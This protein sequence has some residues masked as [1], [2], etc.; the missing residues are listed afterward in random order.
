MQ[1]KTLQ[2]GLFIFLLVAA[3]AL[4]GWLISGYVLPL[5]WAVV[6]TILFHPLHQRIYRATRNKAALSALITMSVI[7]F[8][9][10]IPLYVLGTLVAGEAI[11][12]YT[13]VT[14]SDTSSLQ[15]LTQIEEILAPLSQLGLDVSNLRSEILTFTQNFSAQIGIYALD[16]GRATANTLIATLLMLYILFFSL[17]DG[18]AIGERIKKA[19]PLGDIKEQMLFDRFTSIVHAMFK[20]TFI[21]AI[22][23][24]VI[25]GILFVGVGIESAALWAFVMGIFALIPAV[26]PAIVWLPVGL[27]LLATGAIWQG[28]TVLIT[29]VVIIGLIDN[30]LRPILLSKDAAMPDVLI[31]LSV[32]GGLSLFGI[33]GIIIG[34]VITAFFLSMWELFEHDYAE[35]LKRFG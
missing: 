20:G 17:R 25:G 28:V 23:Q 22:V 31:L 14:Q 26:G 7:L 33:A 18:V 12:I 34:P 35:E 1:F 15:V 6:L 30:L 11:S 29:G 9:V 8:I 4:F 2:T 10:L 24:G 5:F 21:I 27:F 3:T 32:L 19:L 13:S 16:V